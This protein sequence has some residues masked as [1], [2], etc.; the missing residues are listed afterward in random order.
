MDG[1]EDEIVVVT[2]VASNNVVVNST[3]GSTIG[4]Q[5]SAGLVQVGTTTTNLGGTPAVVTNSGNSTNAILNFNIPS[6]VA[7]SNTAPS[8]TQVLWADTGTT[9]PLN[10]TTLTVSGAIT[11]G[12]LNATGAITAG[13]L[14]ATGAI[15][16]TGTITGGTFSGSGS[17]LTNITST[18]IVNIDGG[19]A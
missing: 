11:A 10:L 3:I 6:G 2:S 12:S 15:S 5:G 8:S 19:S 17:L 18:A 4:P 14:S 1:Y 16:A 7:I 13:S 9:V